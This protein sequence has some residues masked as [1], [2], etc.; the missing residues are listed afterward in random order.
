M[1]H[2]PFNAGAE[3]GTG[4]LF[5]LQW[6]RGYAMLLGV[7]VHV[8]LIYST[9][10]PWF[11]TSPEQSW[12]VTVM[13]GWLTSF[14][15]PLFF[16]VAG[17]LSAISVSR[18]GPRTWLMRRAE[19]LGVPLVTSTLVLSPIVFAAM[20]YAASRAPGHAQFGTVFYQFLAW[21]GSHWVGHLWFL[22][23]LLLY[24]LVAVVALPALNRLKPSLL[25]RDEGGTFTLPLAWVFAAAFAV[26]LYTLGEKGTLTVAR[27]RFGFGDPLWEMLRLGQAIGFLPFFLIGLFIHDVRLPPVHRSAWAWAIIAFSLL[28]LADCWNDPAILDKVISAASSGMLAVLGGCMIL[29]LSSRLVTGPSLFREFLAANAFTIYLVHYPI[30]V[31]LGTIFAIVRW[32][33]LAEYLLLVSVTLALCFLVHDAV[34]RSRTLT[35]LVNGDRRGASRKV[36]RRWRAPKLPEP[37]TGIRP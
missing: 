22:Q 7:P 2:S 36:P 29:V 8:G 19:R 37:Q 17:L 23:V 30:V 33:P 12:I 4:R 9:G 16:C 13:T 3:G 10:T 15:M 25:R 1:D 11:V 21:P 14:R 27:T 34:S 24:S 5:Y 26:T 20:A 32:N 35:F 31:W 6:I 28:L 18:H